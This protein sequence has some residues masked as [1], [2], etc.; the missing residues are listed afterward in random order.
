MVQFFW[1]GHI[2]SKQQQEISNPQELGGAELHTSLSG[3][4][5]YYAETEYEALDKIKSI[6]KYTN[7][8]KPEILSKKIISSKICCF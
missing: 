8:I 6:I 5:D 1:E 4:A 2:W 3:V 7:F